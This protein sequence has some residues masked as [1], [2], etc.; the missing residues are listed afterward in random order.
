VYLQVKD[1]LAM[2]GEVVPAGEGDG[3]VRET[4]AALAAD[5]FAGFV[6]L[7]PHLA[8]AGRHGGFSGPDGFRR[9]ARALKLLLDDLAISYR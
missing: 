3:Q 7:E 9:A 6:S 2:T 4:L 1:A 5:G 8:M